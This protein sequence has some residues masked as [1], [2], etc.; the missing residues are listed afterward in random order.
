MSLYKHGTRIKCDGE[1]C[2]ATTHAPVC[3]S[4][5]H[6]TAGW[7]FVSRQGHQ[8]HFCPHCAAEELREVRMEMEK[9]P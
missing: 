5:A 7:L 2:G 3:R 6:L 1:G 9:A 8:Q 4:E